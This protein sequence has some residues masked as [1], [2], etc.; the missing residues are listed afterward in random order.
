[1]T[2]RNMYEAW[3]PT[4]TTSGATVS[5]SITTTG[6][7]PMVEF[8]WT[9]AEAVQVAARVARGKVRIRREGDRWAVRWMAV[10][11]AINWS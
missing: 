7:L 2:P 3:R 6:L 1:M 11:I 5:T 4:T 8:T 10:P 9:W